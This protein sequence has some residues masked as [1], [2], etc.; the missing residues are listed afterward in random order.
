MQNILGFGM[1]LF[2]VILLAGIG[3]G[4]DMIP[5]DAGFMQ[6]ASLACLALGALASG[7]LGISFI[8]KGE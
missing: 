6:W 8:D 5:P 1:V 3:G 4:A 7:L 2:S